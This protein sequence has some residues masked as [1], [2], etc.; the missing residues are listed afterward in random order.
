MP[1]GTPTWKP[2]T[3][4]RPGQYYTP[5]QAYVFMEYYRYVAPVY[6]YSRE[7]DRNVSLG[8]ISFVCS[9]PGQKIIQEGG[10]VPARM[11]VRIV[12]LTSNQ[13]N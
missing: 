9:A 4:A 6:I 13:V 2:D 11:P 7:I 8:F 1:A 3:L 12:Q 10:L 5:A